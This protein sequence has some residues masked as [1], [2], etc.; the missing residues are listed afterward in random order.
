MAGA[1]SHLRS[2]SAPALSAN[3]QVERMFWTYG[4]RGRPARLLIGVLEEL[5]DASSVGGASFDLGS[6]SFDMTRIATGQID[7]YIEPGPRI[8]DEVPGAREAFERVGGGSIL[9]NTPY[10]VAPAGLHLK[11][12]GAGVTDALGAPLGKRP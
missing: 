2:T 5:I 11:E 10:D 6:A 1:T 7:A 4:L 8:V 12:A 3:P 9:N